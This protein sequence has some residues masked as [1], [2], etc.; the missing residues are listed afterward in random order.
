M[1]FMFGFVW[2]RATLPRLRYDQLMDLG[3]KL[4]IPVSLAWFLVLAGIQTGRDRDWSGIEVGAFA[5]GFGVV[6]MLCGALLTMALR[7]ARMQRLVDLAQDGDDSGQASADSG[8]ASA[9]LMA[10]AAH[11]RG[12]LDRAS[13]EPNPAE[14]AFRG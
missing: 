9:D 12:D 4:L 8:Q 11:T 3:W 7:S 6:C 2:V 1:L 10:L 5:V 14:G 13:N